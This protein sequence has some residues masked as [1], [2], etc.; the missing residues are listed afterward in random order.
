MAANPRYQSTTRKPL[1]IWTLALLVGIG[2][3]AG[4]AVTPETP[5]GTQRQVRTAQATLESFLDDPKMAWLKGNLPRAHAILISP[6]VTRGGLGI[7]GSAGEAVVLAQD[8]SGKW[9]GPAFYNLTAGS[10]GLQAGLDV[11]EVIVLV[12]SEKGLTALLDPSLKLGAEASV[13]AGPVSAGKAVGIGR[14]MVSLAR[15]KGAYAGVSFEGATI[16]P[17]PEANRAFYG[18]P[19]SPVDI[20]I[21]AAA[22]NPA[23]V[24]LQQALLQT[25][26]SSGR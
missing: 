5:S 25:T 21:R 16:R 4:C 1:R 11:S 8:K 26:A 14:D 15:S 12:M 17:D 7:G 23:A 24:P 18:K 22:Q 2:A 20:L 13:A 3:A 9:V 6:S 19:V 10:V